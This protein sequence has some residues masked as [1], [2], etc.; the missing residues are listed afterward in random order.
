MKEDGGGEC[1]MSEGSIALIAV[2]AGWGGQ[3]ASNES[4]L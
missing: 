1:A 3:R 4:K 2:G